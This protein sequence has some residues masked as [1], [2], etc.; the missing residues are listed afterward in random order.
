VLVGAGRVACLFKQVRADR[1]QP[2]M[3]GHPLV[4][5]EGGQQGQPGLRALRLG[6]GNRPVEGDHRVGRDPFQ[7]EVGGVHLRP[8][9]LLGGGRVGVGGGDR[10]L[11]LVRPQ[12][13]G[14]QRRLR[15]LG[16]LVDQRPVPAD[17]VLLVQRHQVAG[18]RRARLPAGVGQQHQREQPGHLAV[19]RQLRVHHPGE[20][21]RLAG[22]VGAVELAAGR[23]G[24]PLIEDQVEHVQDDLQPLLALDVVGQAERAARGPDALLGAADPGRHGGL[25]DQERA[26]DLG[27]G[28]AAD[29]AQRERGRRRRGQRRMAAQEEQHERVVGAGDVLG[30]RL[31]RDRALPLAAGVVAAHLVDQPPGGDGH[32]PAAR[33]VGHALGRPLHGGG[34]HGLLDGV[35]AS[36]ELAVPAHQPAEDLRRELAQ[37]VLDGGGGHASS[38][39]SENITWRTSTPSPSIAASGIWAASSIARSLLSQSIR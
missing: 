9:G 23:G 11:Q 17:A 7:D 3:P 14:G 38:V 10:R 13:R 12:G 34:E 29:R 16:A 4:V 21:D 8:V 22:E 36:L 19:V 15:Q 28:Q 27:R 33:A 6:E 30:R 39:P 26:G 32:Q 24:V 31:G 1:Q 25:G 20:P 2:V 37:Q 35:L 18:R 5:V